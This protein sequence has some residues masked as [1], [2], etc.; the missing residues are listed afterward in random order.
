M[1]SSS[2]HS[3][4]GTGGSC[5]PGP[6]SPRISARIGERLLELD[7]QL[8][9]HRFELLER[10]GR[11]ELLEA[12]E[13]RQLLAERRGQ[14]GDARPELFLDRRAQRGIGECDEQGLEIAVGRERA[15]G[16][17]HLNRNSTSRQLAILAR[18]ARR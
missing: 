15:D 14:L 9:K 3:S 16:R 10:A 18:T 2:A 13:P 12:L 6:P 5:R 1:A 7:L 8:R 17:Q 4:P 11:E